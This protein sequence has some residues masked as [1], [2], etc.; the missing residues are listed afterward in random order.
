LNRF[1][2]FVLSAAMWSLAGCGGNS[3]EIDPGV[4]SVELG[5]GGDASFARALDMLER[6]DEY[7]ANQARPQMLY[8]LNRWISDQSP[9]KQWLADPLVGRLPST[10]RT[11]RSLEDL[12]KLEFSSEDADF[13]REAVWLRDVARWVSQRPADHSLDARVAEATSSLEE[14]EAERLTAALRLF[15]WTVRNVQL[16]ELL[17]YPKDTVAG[18]AATPG[19]AP[20]QAN[21]PAPLRGAAGPGYTLYP[22][23]VLLYGHGDAWQRSRLF[24]LLCRQLDID[25]VMLAFDDT[26]DPARPRPWL[27]A[28]LVHGRLYLLD[29]ALGL[30]IPGPEGKGIATLAEVVADAG[31]LRTMDLDPEHRYPIDSVD[32]SKLV[33]LID[34]SPS[35]LSQRMRLVESRLTGEHK[36]V[37]TVSPTKLADRVRTAAGIQ[38]ARLWTVPYEAMM[39]QYALT[40]LIQYNRDIRE[41]YFKE[42]VI[43]L[44]P[45]PVVR[46][47]WQHFR[48]VLDTQVTRQRSGEQ[49]QQSATSGAK[50]QYVE[51]LLSDE[52][53]ADIE[54]SETIAA[55]YGL[56][57][58]AGQNDAAW[59]QVLL[60]AK[61]PEDKL[62]RIV[63]SQVIQKQ[64]NLQR[65][66]TQDV[67]SWRET[68]RSTHLLFTTMKSHATY[69]LGLAHY[70]SGNYD[71]AA[72]FFRRT[73]DAD[74][75]PWHAGA[76]YNLARAQEA[77][78]AVEEA[79]LLYLAEDSSPQSR[80]NQLRARGLVNSAPK[81]TDM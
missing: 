53:L 16:D 4:L 81:K 55:E 41:S 79:R 72:T 40:Q 49:D 64:L 50:P 36:M 25:A 45:H 58:A 14:A 38:I 8:H 73:L 3:P 75:S 17:P 13:L 15:D 57:R 30:P 18:P 56:A 61:I 33:A 24:I 9:D 67:E 28:V 26:G 6:L 71:V 34:A 7:D 22:W 1:S 5:R 59:N 78:G 20:L 32:P 44:S 69:W 66:P 70:D 47:R 68:L 12:S 48:G 80:G 23:Q 62:V 65:G 37:L 2:L 11:I 77:L 76:R 19:A 60:D 63:R 39:Y 21:A 42:Q 46:A 51:A 52:T 31:L 43:F 27:P 29:P 54:A 10:L 35:Y 74:D